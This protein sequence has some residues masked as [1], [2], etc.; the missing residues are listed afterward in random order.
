L[1]QVLVEVLGVGL[2]VI[3]LAQIQ[4]LTG[5][6]LDDGVRFRVGEH[7][8]DLLLQYLRIA[9]AP[10]CSDVEQLIVW[11]AAPQ[12]ERQPRGEI[13]VA[14]AI[15]LTDSQRGRFVFRAVHESW[16]DENARQCLLDAGVEVGRLAAGLIEVHERRE[17]GCAHRPSVRAA[18]ER[19]EDRSRTSVFARVDAGRASTRPARSVR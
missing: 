1:P 14:D 9:E 17:L 15:G 19:R 7:A 13:G 12:E 11:D 2:H 18:R 3:E 8:R 5:E 10:L 6:V 4:P 16:R